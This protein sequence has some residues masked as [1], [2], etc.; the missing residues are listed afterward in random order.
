MIWVMIGLFLVLMLIGIPMAFS[1]A[2]AVIVYIVSV[3]LPP[4]LVPQRIFTTSDNFALMAIP[5][6]MIAGELMNAAGI[7]RRIV[8]FSTAMVGHIRG[9][10]AHSSIIATMIFSGMSGSSVAACASVG[11][12]MIPAMKE[13]GYDPEFGVAVTCSA[14]CFSPIIPPSITFILFGSVTGTSIGALFLGGIIPGIVMA[15]SLMVIAY[16]VSRMRGYPVKPKSSWP[17][18]LKAFISSFSAL[19]MPVLIIAGILSGIFTATEAGAVGI[20]YGLI[21]GLITKELKPKMILK[22]LTNGAMTTAAIMI[23]IASSQILGWVL[24]RAQIPQM[25]T[26]GL[27]GVTTSPTLVLFIIL[28]I[29]LFVGFFMVDAALIPIMA[30]LFMPVVR[31]FGIDPVH[32]GVVMSMMTVTGGITPPVGNL[33]FVACGIAK[34]PV[35]KAFVATAPFVLA[36]LIAIIICALVPPLVTFIP[37]LLM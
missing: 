27:L 25:L 15:A 33:L 35:G 36:L 22:V 26:A 6:F 19:L 24:T 30:P 21:V 5:L 20:A 29:L 23:I 31:Q 10:L 4:E 8:R 11:S 28:G 17:E 2:I 14:A 9:S 7:T 3:G 16:V 1:T 12:M 32:F 34:A 13:E 37:G 18:R